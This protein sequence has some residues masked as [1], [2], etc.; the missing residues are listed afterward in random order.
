MRKLF[1]KA[2]E[3]NREE[4]APGVYRKIMGYESNLMIIYV[5]FGENT[6]F[7]PHK[8]IHQQI[9]FVLE[10]EFEI[11]INGGKEILQKGD[12]YIVPE[13]TLHAVK[14]LKKGAL[15]D[16]FSPMREDFLTK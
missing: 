5:E 7:P 14:C 8:H 16:T 10:G 11:D 9:S 4:I 3:V 6:S 12:A 13:S 15:L 2:K 1:V